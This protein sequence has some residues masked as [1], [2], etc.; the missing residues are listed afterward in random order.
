MV[1]RTPF[2]QAMAAFRDELL[3]LVQRRNHIE[4]R[5]AQVSDAM[6]AMARTCE[7]PTQKA[8]YIDDVRNLTAKIGFQ[9]AIRSALALRGPMTASEI[10]EF[11]GQPGWM[12]L[13]AY[14]N[15]LASIYTTLR[16]M[17]EN[18]EIQETKK[19][20]EKAYRLSRQL[21]PLPEPPKKK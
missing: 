3:I 1:T 8:A 14:S 18:D 17:K 6:E 5:I 15:P 4:T 7:D 16:R 2:E 13:S 19:G 20:E 21:D 10:R 9:S 12:D 11:I